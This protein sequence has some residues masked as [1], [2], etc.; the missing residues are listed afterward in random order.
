MVGSFLISLNMGALS[1][2]ARMVTG[3]TLLAELRSQSIVLVVAG[4]AIH[5]TRQANVAVST[6]GS[7]TEIGTKPLATYIDGKHDRAA[8]PAQL[9][10]PTFF[11]GAPAFKSTRL[12]PP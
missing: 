8:A 1:Q 5:N 6:S 10:R 2:L 11:T 9:D 3:A 12:H 4:N 7:A